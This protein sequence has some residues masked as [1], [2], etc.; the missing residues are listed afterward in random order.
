MGDCPHLDL[1]QAGYGNFRRTRSKLLEAAWVLIEMLIL[2]NPLQPSSLLRAAALRFFGARVGKNVILRPRLRIKF[3]WNLEVGDNCWIG[4]GVWIHNQAKVT[5]GNNTVISQ[6]TF[7]T[8]GSHDIY[9]N[10]DL[11]VSPVTIGDG[12]WITSRCIVLM[13]VTI[14]DCA[15][16]TPGSVV[17]KSV[18]GHAIYGGN[19][20]VFLRPRTRRSSR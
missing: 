20:A 15:V 8:T 19:P 10:M 3:P 6:D 17:H 2:T 14:G 16:V 1:S 13:G 11:I 18:D 4:E 9:G 12:V 7:I 5:I